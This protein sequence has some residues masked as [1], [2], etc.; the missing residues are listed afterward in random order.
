[1]RTKGVTVIESE[2]SRGLVS[3]ARRALEKI[4]TLAQIWREKSCIRP[5]AKIVPGLE[6]LGKVDNVFVKLAHFLAQ[7]LILKH[8]SH[9]QNFGE[10]R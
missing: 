6:P 3:P 9:T 4:W 5:R 10:E 8:L 2:I 7:L 1:M